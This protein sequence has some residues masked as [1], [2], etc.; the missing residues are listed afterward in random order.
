MVEGPDILVDFDAAEGDV[1]DFSLFLFQPA[2]EDLPGSAALRPYISFTQ[3]DA[4]THVQITTP[5]GAMTTEAILLDVMADTLT[6]NVV[7]F[8]PF[9]A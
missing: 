9:L 6:S 4:N 3:V 7:V 5:A 2:F 8:D 1:L